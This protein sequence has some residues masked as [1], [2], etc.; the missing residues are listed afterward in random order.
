MAPQSTTVHATDSTPVIMDKNGTKTVHVDIALSG[1]RC[2]D[3]TV[4]PDDKRLLV[5]NKSNA[6][7]KA[8]D[9]PESVDPYTVEAEMHDGVLS[10]EAAMTC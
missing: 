9:L 2:D 1:Y 8:I 4:R 5:L 10:V 7:L 3:V 6:L